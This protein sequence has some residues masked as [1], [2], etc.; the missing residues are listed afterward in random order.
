MR[1][2]SEKSTECCSSER[3]QT[4]PYPTKPI[5]WISPKHDDR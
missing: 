4:N 2:N 1:R 5:R 3:A